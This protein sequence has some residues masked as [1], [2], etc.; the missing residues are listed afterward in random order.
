MKRGDSRWPENERAH[1]LAIKKTKRRLRTRQGEAKRE[2]QTKNRAAHRRSFFTFARSSADVF[3]LKERNYAYE[4]AREQLPPAQRGVAAEFFFYWPLLLRVIE[5]TSAA[6]R[7]R[8]RNARRL[9]VYC[10]R[11]RSPLSASCG[12]VKRAATKM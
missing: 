4:R 11:Q 12:G 10:K 8:R 3:V 6:S 1:T 5:T 9:F 7:R 2:Q